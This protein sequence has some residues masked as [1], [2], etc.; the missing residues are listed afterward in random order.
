[1]GACVSFFVWPPWRGQAGAPR[2]PHHSTHPMRAAACSRSSRWCRLALSGS[3]HSSSTHV[4]VRALAPPPRAPHSLPPHGSCSM[5]CACTPVDKQ[6]YDQQWRDLWSGGLVPGEV[7]AGGGHQV[8]SGAA[9][10]T[11]HAH[12]TA[13]TH[14][15]CAALHTQ[16]PSQRFDK[17]GASQLLLALLKSGDLPVQGKRTLVPGCGCV[18]WAG[19]GACG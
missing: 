12:C 19:A 16:P 10:G 8:L 6:V 15:V 4:G 11:P 18:C 5:A 2:N 13:V 9:E 3:T 14:P 7:R 17:G 1:V